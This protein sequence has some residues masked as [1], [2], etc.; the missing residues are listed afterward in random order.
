MDIT[1]VADLALGNLT[2]P[3]VLAFVFGVLVVALL[4]SD[5]RLPATVTQVISVYLLL[6]IG[7][8][9][10]VA[11]RGADI[12]DL[13]GPAMAAVGL[14]C[15]IPLLAFAA[16]RWLTR[17]GAVDRG[18]LAAHYGSTSLV[19]FTAA[20][21]MLEVAKI[22][23]DGY[24]ATLLTIMEV[25]GIIVGLL[26]ARHALDRSGVPAR[27]LSRV[28]VGPGADSLIDGGEPGTPQRT[29]WP[30]T[31]RE[32]LTGP[33]V[34]VL[35]GGLVIGAITGPT[36]YSAIEPMFGA[37]FT[38]VLTIYLLHL[39]CVAGERLRDVRAAGPGLIAFAIGFPV[40]AGIAGVFAGS[41]TG[42][43]TGGAVILGVLCASASY[44]AAP[45]AVTLA[46]PQANTGLCLTASLGVTFPFNLVFGIPMLAVIAQAVT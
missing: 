43:S 9:G 37:L 1:T 16:L 4:K 31:L 2:S 27:T 24:V 17:L 8:K 22:P 26:L 33:S 41:F 20:I 12:S 35:V 28:G 39:G 21:A 10:G 7:L 30:K 14:G 23:F 38:G 3:P 18:A 29:D 32:V 36:G 15:G 13:I 11:L 46:L 44:I 42:M 45:A 25:P 40:I 19:T 6:A 34:L 5:L